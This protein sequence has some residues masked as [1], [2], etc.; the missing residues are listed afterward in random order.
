MFDDHRSDSISSHLRTLLEQN[1]TGQNSVFIRAL[2]PT[3]SDT[4]LGQLRTQ[5]ATAVED[6]KL[7]IVSKMAGDEATEQVSARTPL[8]GFKFEDSLLPAIKDIADT[9]G[10]LVEDVRAANKD[11]DFL[12]TIDPKYAGAA[13][14]KVA[15]EAKDRT[16]SLPQTQRELENAKREWRAAA[17]IMVFAMPEQCPQDSSFR[18][19][20]QGYL[21]VYDKDLLDP[22]ALQVA[23]QVAR[24]DALRSVQESGLSGIR[25]EEAKTL[26]DQAIAKLREIATLKS[27]LTGVTKTI[28]EVYLGLENLQQ[29]VSRSLAEARLCLFRDK[30]AAL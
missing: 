3:R 8:K 30:A 26:L 7:T 12:V 4:P 9:F 19:T 13:N 16:V 20:G 29:D 2:D 10:D 11:G 23:Y 21:C 17:A 24:V 28:S 1:L 15:I 6:A 22:T 5:L 25:M 14:L 27:S 18:H